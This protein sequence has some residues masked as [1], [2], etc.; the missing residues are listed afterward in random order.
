MP[1]DGPW[2]PGRDP[3]PSERVGRADAKGVEGA[4][5]GQ[6]IIAEQP[7]PDPGLVAHAS[8]DQCAAAIA[9]G[10]T[11]RRLGTLDLRVRLG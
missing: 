1:R 7:R 6:V 8:T 9:R 2:F 5:T 4:I 10:M 3:V 11:R